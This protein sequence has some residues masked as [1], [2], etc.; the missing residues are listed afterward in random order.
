MRPRVFLAD[1]HRIL[2]DGLTRL[3]E[4]ECQV[5]GTATNGSELLL[6]APRQEV[7]AFVIDIHMPNVG[8]LDCAR[9]LR[10]TMPDSKIIF[11]TVSYDP[12]IAAAARRIGCSA[13]VLK[14]EAG[15]LLLR[16]IRGSMRGRRNRRPE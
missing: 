8:G 16:V 4:P 13:Y 7:D 1:D 12:V 10:E 5:V 15:D 6:K 11:L 3:L 9:A 14:D 2:L